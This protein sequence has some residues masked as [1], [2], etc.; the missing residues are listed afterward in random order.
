LEWET[1]KEMYVSKEI[2]KGVVIYADGMLFCYS[3]KGE[4]AL[5]KA[6]PAGFQVLGKTKVMLGSEQH[7]AHPMIHDG[8]LY[9]RHGKAIIAYKISL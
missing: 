7:W 2:G 9:L 6:D 8:V 5:V 1:G 4:L 3:D